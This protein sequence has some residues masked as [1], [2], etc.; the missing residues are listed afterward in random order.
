V[1][2]APMHNPLELANT[3][4][5]IDALSGG[6]VIAGLGVGWSE[7]EYTA[8]GYDFSNRGARM[9]EI[10]DLLRAAWTDDPVSFHGDHTSFDDIR[11][12]P[13]P[14][15][16]IPI[17]VGGGSERAYRR[18]VTKGDGFQAVGIDPAAAVDVAAR[19]RRD[20]PEETFTISTRTGWDPQGM[21]TGLIKE[22]CA[23]Y[24]DA[25]VQHVVAAPW[26]KD[27]DAWLRSM[28]LLAE[29]VL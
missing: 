19:I 20:R 11:V 23:A 7:A 25:G 10:I 8:L 9:D 27:L 14:A 4:A 17:W 12:L 21:D 5:S 26:Q 2:V 24:A 29:L 6:R 13:K 15:H 22:E 3:L 18:A 16:T 28:D 1:L